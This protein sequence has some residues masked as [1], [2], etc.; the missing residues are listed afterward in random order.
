MPKKLTAAQRRKAQELKREKFL[1]G[2]K[3]KIDGLN[4]IRSVKQRRE[5]ATDLIDYINLYYIDALS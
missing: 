3:D 2:I 5:A 4:R 1:D